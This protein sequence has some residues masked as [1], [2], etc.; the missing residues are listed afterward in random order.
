[1]TGLLP[2]CRR[3]VVAYAIALLR[4]ILLMDEAGVSGRG[5]SH[6]SARGGISMKFDLT[7]PQFMR[8]SAWR[9]LHFWA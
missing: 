5:E 4:P 6:A 2:V 1:M 9:A 3:E 8:R 7:G